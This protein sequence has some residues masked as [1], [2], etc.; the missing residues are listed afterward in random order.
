M[1]RS[2]RLS[3][4]ERKALTAYRRALLRNLG[5]QIRK[6]I[7][8]GSRARGDAAPDADLD[9]AV[10]V[11]GKDRR[12]PE[13]WRPAPFSDP[14]WQAIVDLASDVSLQYAIYISP[15][16]LTEDRLE[17]SSAFVQAIRSEGIEVW[18]SN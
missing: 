13:G 3:L 10:I 7:V 1:K 15:I 2:G 12:T 6:L 9:V 8:Y 14:L 11:E 18:R 17:E 16:V 5:G 4:Q